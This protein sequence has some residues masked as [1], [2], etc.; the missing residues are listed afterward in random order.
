METFQNEVAPTKLVQ[1][2][3]ANRKPN[4][5]L[6]VDA[7]KYS[8][9]MQLPSGTEIITSYIESRGSNNP[10][11]TA[12]VFAGIQVVVK[13]YL[14]HPVT[15][16]DV[17]QAASYAEAMGTP[18]EREGWEYIVNELNG[19]I[20]V[21]IEALPEGT[22][23]EMS[24]VLVQ[25]SNTDKK[26]PWITAF[27][28]T[29]LLRAIWY[30]TTIATNAWTIKKMFLDYATKSGSDKFVDFKLV[31]F[32]ARGVSSGESAMNGGLPFLYL[33]Q[34]TD[35]V[36]AVVGA[37]EFMNCDAAGFSIPATEHSTTTIWGRTPE[38]ELAAYT[39]MVEKFAKPDALFAMVID[40]YNREK[41]VEM[42]SDKLQ[43]KII[44]S[45]ATA[46]L[47][48][49]SGVPEEEPIEVILQLMDL[50]GFTTND[51]GYKTLPP[52]VRVL[53]GDGISIDSIPDILANLDRNKLTLDNLS[54]GMGGGTLQLVNRDILK[55]AQKTNNAIINGVSR[56]VSKNPIGDS[57]KR[58]KDG[59]LKCF[60][61]ENGKFIT[62]RE[63]DP[64]Y[65]FEKSALETVYFN[66]ELLR[67]EKLVDIRNRIVYDR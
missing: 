42:I 23:V 28:E 36:E 18:F 12:N 10:I 67:D 22:V 4:V 35:T 2:M 61:Q 1:A 45:G 50:W 38:D 27:I 39:N 31:D 34:A 9:P 54:F 47:R 11:Y 48:P 66:G 49:D 52:S 40:S 65:L 58:S 55:F 57:S 26:V 43:Q 8:H 24:N 15:Q 13:T 17:E 62:V 5:I 14:C 41:A 25:I 6:A 16:A 44:D 51:Q 30:A 29:L 56:D 33:F 32:G 64:K 53:Q 60:Q 46:V 20:P 21:K 7:Y 59:V 19:N 3:F 63:D 37:R